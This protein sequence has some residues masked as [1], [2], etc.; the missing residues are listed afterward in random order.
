MQRTTTSRHRL[1]PGH[2][3]MGSHRAE[4]QLRIVWEELIKRF[5]HV[6]VVGEPVRVQ[7][8][9]VKGYSDLPVRIRA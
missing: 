7:S 8:F 2:A 5:K 9:F 6:E 1:G 4:M 3:C